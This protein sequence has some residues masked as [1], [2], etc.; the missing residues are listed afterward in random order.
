MATSYRH[1][2][3]DFN[4][5]GAMIVQLRKIK[6]EMLQGIDSEED[7]DR[8][9]DISKMDEF[10]RKKYE[11]NTILK[12]TRDGVTKFQEIMKELGPNG[13]DKASIRVQ[14][15]NNKQINAASTMWQEL[16]QILLK[17]VNKKGKKNLGP[18]ELEDRRAVAKL[19]GREIV[20]LA[21]KNSTVKTSSSKSITDM[22]TRVRNTTEKQRDERNAAK[23][24]RSNKSGGNEQKEGEVEVTAQEQA[25]MD[26][27]VI[28]VQEQDEILDEI[29]A[30]IQELYQLS[31]DQNKSLRLQSDMAV[32]LD[33]K[34]DKSMVIMEAANN[35]LQDVL[36]KSGGM[37][38]W[39]PLLVCLVILVALGAYI[40]NMIAAG[41]FGEGI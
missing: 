26:Q 13:R 25:F 21:A 22:T 30:G 35:R 38:R 18:K 7:T 40:F 37:T 1:V 9:R 11:I 12:S 31:M 32:E 4:K 24:Q 2:K 16:Q 23:G 41:K 20:D 8:A 5:L 14:A 10:G 27:V 39:C 34:M 17:D 3:G 33:V 6:G 28:N 36:E 15:A 29:S 19:L